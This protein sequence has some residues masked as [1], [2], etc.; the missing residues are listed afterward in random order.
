MDVPWCAPRLQQLGPRAV[1]TSSFKVA[2][3]T[4]A[5]IASTKAAASSQGIGSATLRAVQTVDS[6]TRPEPETRATIR[7]FDAV[8]R[9]ISRRPSERPR[10]TFFILGAE[11]QGRFH[12]YWQKANQLCAHP[13]SGNRGREASLCTAGMSLLFAD[14]K[15]IRDEFKDVYL[16]Q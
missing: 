13:N 7:A 5:C 3:Q 12:S 8:R 11:H 10:S 14:Y 16:A 9:K 15:P 2:V 4:P 1:I 6:R